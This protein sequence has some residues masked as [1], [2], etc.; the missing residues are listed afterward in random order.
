M[1]TNKK[2]HPVWVRGLKLDGV[3][4]DARPL[5]VAPRVGAWIETY[6]GSVLSERFTVA[7]RVGAWIET[8]P[9]KTGTSI[10]SRQS[11]PV[12]VRG[13][14]LGVLAR[15]PLIYLSHPVWVRGL[16]RWL[17]G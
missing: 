12:W 11:H 5:A 16:K 13:L 4:A 15:I 6:L 7:P 1:L 14:K 2:S 10:G 17:G 3:N 8:W 9:G